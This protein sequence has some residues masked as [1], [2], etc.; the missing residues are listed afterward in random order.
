[1]AKRL[2]RYVRAF[3]NRSLQ[4]LARFMPGA[5]SFRIWCHKMRG[6]KMGKK[7]WLGYDLILETEHPD[8]IWI[9]NDVEI[10]MRSTFIAHFHGID[11]QPKGPGLERISIK[12]E[13]GVFIG[14]GVIVLPN[15]VIGQGAAVAAGS[16]VTKNVPRMTL[17]QG[18]PAKPVATCGISL[19]GRVRYQEFL[20][21][22]KPYKP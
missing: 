10:N 6:I 13:D 7:V 1:M 14:P 19:A 15:V 2:K 9:G 11:I 8:W 16:V 3:K 20:K 12:I 22:L 4:H 18:N 21:K 17:V 5:T